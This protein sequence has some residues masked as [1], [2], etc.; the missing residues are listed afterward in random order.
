MNGWEQ[1]RIAG[2][3]TV[4]LHHSI[5]RRYS[6]WLQAVCKW[7]KEEKKERKEGRKEGRNEGRNE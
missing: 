4:R 3:V 5:Y 7:A 6:H 1:V 2:S